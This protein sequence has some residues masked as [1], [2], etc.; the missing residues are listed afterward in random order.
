MAHPIQHSGQ[1]A[2]YGRP[3]RQA[4]I[5]SCCRTFVQSI[6]LRWWCSKLRHHQLL[7]FSASASLAGGGTARRDDRAAMI[8]RKALV[9]ACRRSNTPISINRAIMQVAGAALG[10]RG[11]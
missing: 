6:S 7:F 9:V 11:R 3:C 5:G 8:G 10:H 1:P 2:A 4:T